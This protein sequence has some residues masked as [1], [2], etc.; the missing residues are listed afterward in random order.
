MNWSYIAARL[1]EASSWGGAAMMLLAALHVNANPDAVNAA[2][3]IVAAI[4]GLLAILIPDKGAPA[5]PNQV[6]PFPPINQAPGAQ[7]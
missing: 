3:G 5:P 1:K 6:A 7:K 4:G 2:L